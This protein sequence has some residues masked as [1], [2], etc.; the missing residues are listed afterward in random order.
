[1]AT[2]HLRVKTM[3]IKLLAVVL[4]GA[5]ALTGCEESEHAKALM[6]NPEIT[7]VGTFDGCTTKYVNRGYDNLS[8][9]QSKCGDTVATTS[10]FTVSH[11]KSSSF[12]RRVAITQQIAKLQEEQKAIDADLAVRHEALSKLSPAE[13]SAL[14]L[15]ASDAQGQ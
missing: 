4:I 6:A 5:V 13:R 14:G 10:N 3:K 12:E 15:A 9:Y 7:V 2:I 8:F 11:G 1:M